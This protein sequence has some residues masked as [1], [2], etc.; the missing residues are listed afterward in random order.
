MPE[1]TQRPL[2]DPLTEDSGVI[3]LLRSGHLSLDGQGRLQ[4]ADGAL[5]STQI[6]DGS[7]QQTDLAF[8]V[9]SIPSAV[10]QGKAVADDGSLYDSVQTAVNNATDWVFVG[11]GTYSESVTVDKSEFAL[12]GAGQGTVI[13]GQVDL[14]KSTD[15]TVSN[16]QIRNSGGSPL[17]TDNDGS[18]KRLSIHDIYISAAGVGSN[19]YGD[20]HRITNLHA[21]IKGIYIYGSNCVVDAVV[22]SVGD[23]GSGNTVGDIA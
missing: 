15:T 8:S 12:I 7:I 6:S 16:L 19:I 20:G 21:D 17:R 10:Q 22:G 3:D 18:A 9:T 5:G 23:N 4:V 14:A 2:A 13:D 1:R 11:P